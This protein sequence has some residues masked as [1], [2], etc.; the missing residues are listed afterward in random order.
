[1]SGGGRLARANPGLIAGRFRVLAGA[2][3]TAEAAPKPASKSRAPVRFACAVPAGTAD[4][5]ITAGGGDRDLIGNDGIY[6]ERRREG[7]RRALPH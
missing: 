4:R 7:P 3:S 1:M 5:V 2:R 6:K